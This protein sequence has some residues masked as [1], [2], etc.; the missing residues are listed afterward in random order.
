M[1]TA[2]YCLRTLNLH[3]F[4]VRSLRSIMYGIACILETVFQQI[5]FGLVC[6][7]ENFRKVSFSLYFK[8]V[9][10]QEIMSCVY[11][12]HIMH[13]RLKRKMNSLSPEWG[14]CLLLLL[15]RTGSLLSL[16]TV[17]LGLSTTQPPART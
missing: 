7:L 8:F 4:S 11:E 9:F 2:F 15:Q 10:P 12:M 5:Q 13:A 17:H 16:S 14:S 6:L 1:F 3:T